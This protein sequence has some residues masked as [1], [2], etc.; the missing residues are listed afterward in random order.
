M[1]KLTK[2]APVIIPKK[3]CVDKKGYVLWN[4][5]TFRKN[6]YTDHRKIRIGK[7]VDLINWK[8][9]RMMYPNDNYF[10]TFNVVPPLQSIQRFR[11]LS[12]GPYIV[13]RKLAEE[14]GL[15]KILCK[16][17]EEENA[18]LL[19]DLAMFMLVTRDSVFQPFPEWARSHATFSKS[20]RSG[21]YISSFGQEIPLPVIEEFKFLWAQ[22]IIGRGKVFLCYDSTNVN[23]QANG[24][25]LVESFSI[26]R[27]NIIY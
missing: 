13:I 19:V 14:S 20:I 1:S 9:N 22:H 21:S 24:A 8:E 2:N 26:N 6:G 27:T 25:T 12:I 18:Y 17:F 4:E 11:Y 15:L 5:N 23:S 7:V 3:S 10:S 16:V